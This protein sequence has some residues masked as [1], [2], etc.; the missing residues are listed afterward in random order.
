MGAPCGDGARGSGH[1][2]LHPAAPS[3]VERTRRPAEG[4]PGMAKACVRVLVGGQCGQEAR[5]PSLCPQPSHLPSLGLRALVF[6]NER[7]KQRWLW[8]D[9]SEAPPPRFQGPQLFPAAWPRLPPGAGSRPCG[10]VPSVYLSGNYLRPGE[11]PQ[12]A[13]TGRTGNAWSTP[14]PMPSLGLVRSRSW[15]P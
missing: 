15:G 14:A 9:V 6:S 1:A 12:I 3:Q 7:F 2:P 13:G 10:T 5:K 8:G 4:A 11:A